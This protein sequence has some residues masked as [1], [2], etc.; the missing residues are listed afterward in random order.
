M[1]QAKHEGAISSLLGRQINAPSFQPTAWVSNGADK[2]Q[3]NSTWLV[4]SQER[5]VLWP[6]SESRCGYSQGCSN[7]SRCNA[8]AMSRNL[9]KASESKSSE[10]MIRHFP[11]ELTGQWISKMMIR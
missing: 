2:F 5:V 10:K 7:E 8:D 6:A 11:A 1:V 3:E 4:K 9:H